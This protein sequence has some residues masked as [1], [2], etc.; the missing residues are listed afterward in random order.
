MKIIGTMK[1]NE[2]I[3]TMDAG[4]IDDMQWM[5][6]VPYCDRSD[7]VGIYI[8]INAV[9]QAVET[10]KEMQAYK[11]EVKSMMAKFKKLA[12]LL[13]SRTDMDVT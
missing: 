5:A 7:K 13:D 4:E 6:G 9:K 8:N 11:K 2:R 3:V 1:G 10:V 12:E